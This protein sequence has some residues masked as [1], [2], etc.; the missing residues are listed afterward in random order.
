MREQRI[1]ART[2]ALI[3][4]FSS[5][6]AISWNLNLFSIVGGKGSITLASALAPTLGLILGPAVGSIVAVVGGLAGTLIFCSG[7]LGPLSFLPG[8]LASLS[9]GLLLSG[10]RLETLIFYSAFLALL[11]VHPV[12][13]LRLYPQFFLMHIAGLAIILAS[14]K[15]NWR[16]L[17]ARGLLSLWLLFLASL[18][19][20]HACGT[21]TFL[22][23]YWPWVIS[24]PNS[25]REIW[26]AVSYVYPVER[27][28]MATLST[29]FG[30]PA[31]RAVK[32]LKADFYWLNSSRKQV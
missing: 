8:A 29:L 6:Y 25:W 30:V 7:A 12:G 4:S 19:V 2:L 18:L 28:V 13:P 11:L 17:T 22:A 24:S 15:L 5:L 1:N 32:A 23:L 3:A 26:R 10:R 21:L 16:K 9:S 31:L 27:A 14:T 20:G